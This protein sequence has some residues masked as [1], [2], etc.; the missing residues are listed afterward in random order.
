MKYVLC[1]RELQLLRFHSNYLLKMFNKK[2]LFLDILNG[3]F[4]TAYGGSA[5]IVFTA[6][7]FG[8]RQTNTVDSSCIINQRLVVNTFYMLPN[9]EEGRLDI[10]APF[11]QETYYPDFSSYL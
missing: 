3:Y 7:Y 10:H 5:Q 1:F 4:E 8:P 11:T 9:V 6:A 2:Q